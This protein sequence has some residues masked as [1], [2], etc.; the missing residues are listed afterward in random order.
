MTAM[1]LWLTLAGIASGVLGALLAAVYT[2]E[3]K[4]VWGEIDDGRMVREY[5]DGKPRWWRQ[6]RWQSRQLKAG[7]LLIVLGALLLAAG[8]LLG[9]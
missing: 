6:L 5:R 3:R 7:L 2:F 4:E 8:A 9:R 1:R